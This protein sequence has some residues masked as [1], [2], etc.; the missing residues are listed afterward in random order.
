MSLFAPSAFNRAYS[1]RSRAMSKPSAPNRRGVDVLVTQGWG[2][3]AYN[4]VRSL[5]RERLRV[6]VGTD[7]LG[8]MAALSKYATARFTHPFVTVQTAAFVKSV[9]EALGRYSPAVYL[10]TSDDTYVASRFI[11]LFEATGTVVPLA[12]FDTI[13]TLHKKNDVAA[14]ASSLGIPIPE[15]LI[16]RDDG[17]SRAF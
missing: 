9:R 8:G 13:R 14:L 6:V 5:G 15:T 10:P 4:V 16:P 17:D 11:D 12:P 2:K 7:R 3:I 1:G